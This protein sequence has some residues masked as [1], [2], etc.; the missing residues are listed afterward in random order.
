MKF[1]KNQSKNIGAV[2]A[3]LVKLANTAPIF[4]LI[5]QVTFLRGTS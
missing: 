2:L 4:L 3:S 1:P 5:I